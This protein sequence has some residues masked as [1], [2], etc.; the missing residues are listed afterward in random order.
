MC[1]FCVCVSVDTVKILNLN[2]CQREGEGV[3]DTYIFKFLHT[4]FCV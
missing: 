3:Y 4:A 2:A 1:E